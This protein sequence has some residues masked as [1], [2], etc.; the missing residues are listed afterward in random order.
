ML[1]IP[2]SIQLYLCTAPSSALT[3]F[4]EVERLTVKED[5]KGSQE[6]VGW[7][8]CEFPSIQQAVV[9]CRGGLLEFRRN[10]REE[11]DPS[12]MSVTLEVK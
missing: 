7:F 10:G 8:S 3:L 11:R 9:P 1:E 6:P 12:L 4:F 2:E 5:G